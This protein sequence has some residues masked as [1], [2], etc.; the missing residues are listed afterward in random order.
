MPEYLVVLSDMEFDSARGCYSYDMRANH[1][2][3]ATLMESIAAK[4]RAYDL[5]MPNLIF[6]NVQARQDN[7]PMT[8]KDGITFVSGFSPVLF[9][10]IMK[11]KTA[12]DL[13]LDVLDGEM[14]ARV[15]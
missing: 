9:E 12:I 7:I 5:E 13:M 6:W 2:T 8:V 1:T 3:P 15:K 14:Y 10:Q 11:G 4:W